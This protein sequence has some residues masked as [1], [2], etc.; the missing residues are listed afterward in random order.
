MLAKMLRRKLA[1]LKRFAGVYR[2]VVGELSHCKMGPP[3]ESIL[4]TV[5]TQDRNGSFVAGHLHEML[6]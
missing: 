6:R 4:H 5:S 2:Y 3:K 1:V